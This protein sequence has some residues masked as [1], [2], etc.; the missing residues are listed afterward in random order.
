MPLYLAHTS[1]APGDVVGAG[2]ADDAQQLT[3]RLLLVASD[4][5]RSRLYHGLKRLQ[6]ARAPLLVAEL[7]EPPKFKHMTRGS[8]AWLRSVEDHDGR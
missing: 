6:P 1:A 8:H 2:L 3:E 4:L 5:T 7:A